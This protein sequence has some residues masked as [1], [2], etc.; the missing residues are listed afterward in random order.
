MENGRR[1]AHFP[2]TTMK[3]THESQFRRIN[4]DNPTRNIATRFRLPGG[5]W[6]QRAPAKEKASKGGNHA[7][8]VA[9]AAVDNDTEMEDTSPPSAK[10]RQTLTW[11]DV[12]IPALI[13]P[14]GRMLAETDGLGGLHG[15]KKRAVRCTGCDKGSAEPLRVLCLYFDHGISKTLS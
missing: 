1:D 8:Q 2:L 10:E 14:Y 9:T 12:V 5:V 3:R 11:R 13:E 15:R 6:V 7:V 4:A